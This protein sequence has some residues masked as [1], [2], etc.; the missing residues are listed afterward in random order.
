MEGKELMEDGIFN[1]IRR[2]FMESEFY[3]IGFN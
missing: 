3:G 2:I 1:I